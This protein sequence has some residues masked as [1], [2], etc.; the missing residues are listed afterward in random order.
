MRQDRKK[1]TSQLAPGLVDE[2]IAEHRQSARL[3]PQEPIFHF[4]LAVALLYKHGESDEALA[5]IK[6]TQ[7]LIDRGASDSVAVRLSFV[8]FNLGKRDA[9]IALMREQ[10]RR[11]P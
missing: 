4:S 11:Y 9:A 5:E 1:D 10:V 6:E 8:L 3:Q 7:T 2:S